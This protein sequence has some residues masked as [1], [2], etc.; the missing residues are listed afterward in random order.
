MKASI[1]PIL[2]S[3]SLVC[4]ACQSNLTQQSSTATTPNTQTPVAT[5]KTSLPPTQTYDLQVNDPQVVARLTQIAF[6]DD[7]VV[8]TMAFTNVSQEPIQLN[9]RDDLILKDDTYN[10]TYRLA[11]PPD[12]PKIQIQ[13]G[14]TLK[15]QFVFIGRVSPKATNLDISTNSSQ[16]G[17]KN[18]PRVS[19]SNVLIQRGK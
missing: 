8:V 15:G 9:S 3:I 16:Y 17:Y 12:N 5:P 11:T 1:L 19:F 4:I 7:S 14:T 18:F 10:S 6:T 13:P 2:T